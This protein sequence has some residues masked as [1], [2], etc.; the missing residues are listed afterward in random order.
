LRATHAPD[1]LHL[2]F[3]LALAGR[4][5]IV[6]ELGRGGMGIVY[7]A[8]EVHLDRLVAIKLLPPEKAVRHRDG[9][10]REARFAAKL[11][12][13]HVIP[14]HAVDEIDGFVFYVMA[15]VEGET[16]GERVHTRGPLS[17]SEGVRVLREVAWALGYAHAQGVVHRDVKPD[18]ILLESSTGRALVAD[19]GI[20]AITGDSSGE[21]I[22]GT[23]EFMSPEQ[24]LGGEVD[25][26]SDLYAWGATAFYVLSGR[27]PF[28][29]G[30][31]AE[32]LARHVSEPPPS[33][34]SIGLAV[35]RRV[36]ALV[37][38][39]LAKDPAARPAG[40]SVLAEEME[41][42][43]EQRRE[44]PVALRAFVRRNGRMGGA[45]T[46]LY[47]GALLVGSI[48]VA[49]AA[50][51]RSAVGTLAVGLLVAPLGFAVFSAGRL[52]QLGFTHADLAPAFRL[53][54][55]RWSEEHDV[56]PGRVGRRLERAVSSI[57]EACGSFAALGLP[58]I[59]LGLAIPGTRALALSAVP[60]TL[61]T[62][63]LGLFTG[64]S[65]LLLVQRRRDVDTEVWW[66]FWKGRLGRSAFALARRLRRGAVPSTPMTHRA[67]E[68]SLGMAAEQ[69]FE[70]LSRDVRKE[71]GELPSVLARLQLDA[72]TL[73]SR[74][75]Q[76]EPLV[77]TRDADAS[78]QAERR[79]ERDVVARKLADVVGALETIRLNLLRLHADS[80][81][82]PGITTHL[83][84]AEEVSRD[85][86]RLLAAR[87]DVD[88][89]LRFPR[90]LEPTPA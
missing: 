23:P 46:L 67:T 33:L 87:S 68:L 17:A 32:V 19:F 52:L 36:A 80:S 2:A 65:R 10:V 50:G 63:G 39:C 89:A 11:N 42:A 27:V 72:Q 34:T 14:I 22:A 38:R 21:S 45:G 69:L 90:R 79:A 5:T 6:R 54:L 75:E 61:A 3:Q 77:A 57:T 15:F 25:T 64:I 44:L 86:E 47:A 55:E 71:L 66:A 85:V 59:L 31:P 53:E 58:A 16:L 28:D 40:A 49:I 1:A 56:Q 73:R 12:H 9:F 20:A 88:A 51:Q 83:E 8:R 35:P 70:S 48:A 74:L 30:S 18:N 24:A 29:G 81:A 4:Y 7:L 43:L 78:A 62:V 84:L 26:R 41:L 76:L 82:L 60:A 13:P 37:D